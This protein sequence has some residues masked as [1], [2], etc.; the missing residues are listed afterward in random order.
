M[1]VKTNFFHF[2]SQKVLTDRLRSS[3]KKQVLQ[4]GL[5]ANWLNFEGVADDAVQLRQ[6]LAVRAPLPT[7]FS[8]S[9]LHFLTAIRM[10]MISPPAADASS[11]GGKY[12]TNL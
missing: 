5:S 1:P 10:V 8:F 4:D 12:S 11:R 9:D 3:L 7:E 2:R 6:G